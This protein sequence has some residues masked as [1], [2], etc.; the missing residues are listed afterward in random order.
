MLMVPGERRLSRV[1][2][3]SAVLALA[4]LPLAGLLLV[5]SLRVAIGGVPALWVYAIGWTLFVFT[6]LLVLHVVD[7]RLGG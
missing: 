6:L 3:Y 1:A 5:N 7:V 4:Y 2:L